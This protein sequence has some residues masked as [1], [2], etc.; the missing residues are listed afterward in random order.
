MTRDW[1][2]HD[3]TFELPDSQIAQEPPHVRGQSRLMV[4]DPRTQTRSHSMVS[5]LINW[6][7]PGTL[8]VFNDTKVRKARVFGHT[9]TGGKV[10]L[11]LLRPLPEGSWECLLSRSKKL[12]GGQRLNLPGGVKAQVMSD[13][14][15]VRPVIFEPGI[16]DEWLT[17]HGHLPL[18]PYIKRPDTAEDE[19]RY[20]TVYA[21]DSGSAAAPTAGLHFTDLQLQ[22][23][24]K[25][26]VEMA[27]LT[28]EVG[29]GTFLPVRTQK[30]SEHKMHHEEYRISAA[31]AAQLNRARAEGRPILAVGTT[32]LRTL[33]A[34]WTPEGYCEG[35]GST[36]L[37]IT[38]GYQFRG[39][40]Q[41][42][43]NFHTPESTLLM[44]VCAFAGRD[45]LLE[46]YR[47]AVLHQYRFFSYG[48][49]MLIRTKG[50][51][52]DV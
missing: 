29:L 3:F 43:T 23:L 41:L 15:A 8:M 4:I 25:N 20:Q 24:Q 48:D 10:E 32:S 28:L 26:T 14:G 13:A 35:P 44:L 37:F 12:R 19:A 18:P 11:I 45:F 5:E 22:S 17:E 50:D 27:F 49:A 38:P 6:V 42:F 31:S 16:D 21:Q 30:V 1:N 51:Q 52:A 39:I 34:A 40:D 33:E 47:Q 9:E 46:S 36:N 2:L 7:E